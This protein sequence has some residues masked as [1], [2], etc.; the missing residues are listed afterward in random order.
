MKNKNS[1]FRML[2]RSHNYQH[3]IQNKQAQAVVRRITRTAEY[4]SRFCGNIGRTTAVGEVWG[5]I[6]RMNGVRSDWDLPVLKS[7]EIVAVRD[8]EKAE[9]LAQA[10]V[11]VHSSNNLTEERQLGREWV[12]GEHP[13]VLDQRVMVGDTLR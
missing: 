11:K 3:L 4:W 8:M 9:M 10:F 7:G 6:K 2:K 13:G 1:T 12:R 5:M